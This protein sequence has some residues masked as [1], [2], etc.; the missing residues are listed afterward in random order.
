[1]KTEEILVDT[2]VL[3]DVLEDDPRW[4]EWS[5]DQLDAASATNRLVINPVIYSELSIGFTRIEG[6]RSGNRVIDS[7]DRSCQEIL[8]ASA[9]PSQSVFCQPRI[10]PLSLHI[11]QCQWIA[12]SSSAEG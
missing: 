12:P 1:M 5:Q 6:K 9:K 8:S 4:A 10:I 3:L 7:D 11:G 2:N